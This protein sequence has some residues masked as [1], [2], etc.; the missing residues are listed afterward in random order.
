MS[1]MELTQL[2][3]ESYK[4]ATAQ[5]LLLERVNRHN[6][7]KE[8]DWKEQKALLKR[9]KKLIDRL[10][11]IRDSS[12]SLYRETIDRLLPE[13]EAGYAKAIEEAA[14]FEEGFMLK[15]GVHQP[16]SD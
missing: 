9:R 7:V 11:A 13:Q 8:K 3:I 12:S 6:V 14:K 2:Q 10:K 15:N 5:K 4:I 1:F 16:R